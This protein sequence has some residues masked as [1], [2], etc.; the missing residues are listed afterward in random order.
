MPGTNQAVSGSRGMH[1]DREAEDRRRRV[2]DLRATLR[3]P[4]V[5]RKTPLW[6][7]IQSASGARGALHDA[8]RVLDVGSSAL[9]RHV[10]GEHAVACAVPVSP[11]SRAEP[12]AAAR[13]A[14]PDD[15]AGC[16][17]IDADR[18]DAGMVG[19]AAEPLACG[20]GGPTATRR[21]PSCRRRRG[22]E[23][24]AGDRAAPQHAGALRALRAPRRCIDLPR[25]R[26][27]AHRIDVDDV[28]GLRRVRGTG[29][30]SQVAPPSRERC[31]FTPKWPRSWHACNVPS[32]FGEVM[33][34]GSPRSSARSMRQS[35]PRRPTMQ[36][37]LRVPTSSCRAILASRKCL[38]NIHFAA[39]I[40]AIREVP[41]VHDV[42]AVD[43]DLDVPANLALVVENVAAHGW[44]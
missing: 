27:V 39:S 19:A 32:A 30:S 36:S 44:P 14:E 7:W 11:P 34:T 13:D 35:R 6:C 20:P 4:S 28:L 1:G 10:L 25:D 43:E 21:A 18:V 22:A 17:R 24:A 23:Q 37:P 8:V 26:R 33:V 2:R 3:P 42:A 5:Q 29:R 15:V 9:G 40:D 16:A 41:P 12:D 38:K 31:I